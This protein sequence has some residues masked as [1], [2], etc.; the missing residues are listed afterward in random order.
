MKLKSLALS[1]LALGGICLT[2]HATNL[3]V[4]MNAVSTTMTLAPLSGGNPVDAGSPTNNIY[5]FDVE[6]G[7]YLLTAYAKDGATVNGTIE[8]NV[9]PDSVAQQ[10]TVLTL[11]TYA[12]NKNWVVDQ[13]YTIRAEAHSREGKTQKITMGNSVTAGRKTFLALNG[14]SYFVY[15][16]PSE[17]HEKEGYTSLFKTGTLTGNINISGA[18][19]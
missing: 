13:D 3:T 11:T 12:T 19:P 2:T 17:E 18:I 4:K 7:D 1:L 16:D 15:F 10:I 6:G 14:N 9:D 8:I 5:K